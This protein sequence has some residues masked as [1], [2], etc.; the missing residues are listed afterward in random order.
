MCFC[1]CACGRR[2]HWVL[3]GCRS[4]NKDH[5]VLR[6][7]KKHGRFSSRLRKTRA[8]PCP[9]EHDTCFCS[10]VDPTSRARD[11]RDKCLHWIFQQAE[12]YPHSV[13]RLLQSGLCCHR[14]LSDYWLVR[15][16]RLTSAKKPLD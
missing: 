4:A 9:T 12:E 11:T 15:S 8:R 13:I 2:L 16:C 1:D 10:G 14:S 7:S 6:F 5:S 3:T